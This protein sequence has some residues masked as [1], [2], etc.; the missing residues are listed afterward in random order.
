[1]SPK[2]EMALVQEWFD[3]V[4]EKNV[5]MSYESELAIQSVLSTFWE[6]N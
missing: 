6:T 1:M 2:D 4:H 3:V 5:L